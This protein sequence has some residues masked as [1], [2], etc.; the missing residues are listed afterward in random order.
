MS[1]LFGMI[2]ANF[3]IINIEL[4]PLSLKLEE[5]SC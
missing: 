2:Q 3:H 1:D 5:N 4:K